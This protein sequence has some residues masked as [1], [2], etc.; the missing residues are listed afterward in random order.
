[1]LRRNSAA[2]DGGSVLPDWGYAI[3]NDE[4]S[5]VAHTSEFRQTY[6]GYVRDNFPPPYDQRDEQ[7]VVFLEGTVDHQTSDGRW[8]PCF[9][10]EA[11]YNDQ[12][13]ETMVEPGV[14]VFTIWEQGQM[15]H[16]DEWY[17]PTRTVV[18]VYHLMG[19]PEVTGSMV[20]EGLQIIRA[21][22]AAERGL[23]FLTYLLFVGLMPWTHDNYMSYSP[24]GIRDDAA[25]S[26]DEDQATWDRI[27]GRAVASPSA[28]SAPQA[29]K[30]VIYQI[31]REL[32][33]SGKIR[34][35]VRYLDDGSA[36]IGIPE[37]SA[38]LG[39]NLLLPRSR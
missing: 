19:Y 39:E 17:A 23:S 1:M 27:Q 3:L 22:M 25:F 15:W 18:S 12:T 29:E 34:V 5:A 37:V 30:S 11:V 9:L 36:I 10:A 8:H 6:E 2:R 14:D 24:G 20:V 33:R 13:S 32:L 26:A 35:P 21:G 7:Q 31:G 16:W 28:H 4:L 38:D